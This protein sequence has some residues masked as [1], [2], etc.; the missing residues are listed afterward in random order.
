MAKYVG[1]FKDYDLE[2]NVLTI[3]IEFITPEEQ[4][5]LE[6]AVLERQHHKFNHSITNNSSVSLKQTRCWYGSLRTILVE[7]E[8]LPTSFKAFNKIILAS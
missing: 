4:A 7:S 6:K 5:K 3:Q 8:L 2:N 1:S